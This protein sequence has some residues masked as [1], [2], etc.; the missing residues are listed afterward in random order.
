ATLWHCGGY[1]SA[2]A[3]SPDGGT[4]AVGLYTGV[5]GLSSLREDRARRTF[6]PDVDLPDWRRS[7]PL[8]LAFSP[9]G[10]L[11]AV[12]P[13][14]KVELWDIAELRLARRLE[15]GRRT[16]YEGRSLSFSPDGASLVL[17]I[18]SGLWLWEVASG[19]PRELK[20]APTGGNG[21]AFAPDGKALGV[22]GD[23]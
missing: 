21:A 7:R 8:D 15:S 14:P 16:T 10:S 2:L 3:A 17:V 4:V 12:G 20:G 1:V 23:G 18:D 13:D 9:D 22:L 6:I 19:A 5:V 11:L